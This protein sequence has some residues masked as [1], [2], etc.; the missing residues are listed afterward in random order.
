MTN[1]VKLIT[2][3][4]Y[5]RLPPAPHVLIKLID[6]CH[7][8]DVSF[9]ELEAII[10]KDTALCAKVITISN[11]AAYSQWNETRELKRILVVLGTKTIKSIAITSAVHQFFSQF[12]KEMGETLGSAWLD[13]LICAH[14]ARKLANLT[15]YPF[16]DEAHLAGLIHQ[17]GQLILYTNDPA[18]YQQMMA[19]VSDQNALMFK[20]QER[21]G[22]NSADLA[23]D[24]VAQWG[25]DS[26]LSDAIRY[27]HKPAEL[28]L[29]THP[30][31]RLTS[32]SSQLCNRLNHNN[33]KFMAE[34]Q[35]FGLNQS[36]IENLVLEATQLAVSD[37]RGFG[38][39]VDEDHTIPRANVDQESIRI[40]LAKKMRQIALLEGVQKNFDDVDD[41][42]EMIQLISDQLLLL[43]G[44]SSTMFFFPDK[45][46]TVL[47]GFA[48]HSKNIPAS[49]S[50]S[51]KLK[52]NRSLVSEAALQ[53]QLKITG[54]QT[55]FDDLP[56]IDVQILSSL[57]C[58]EMICL[59]LLHN[60]NLIAVIA[61]G[62]NS[63]ITEKFHTDDEL[64]LHFATIV[65]EAFSRQH[66]INNKYQQQLLDQ[67]TEKDIHTRKVIHEI[68]NP[69]SIIN[70]YLELLSMGMDPESDNKQ[71]LET[72]KSEVHRVS[73]IL[74]QL[75]DD[76]TLDDDHA[77]VNINTLINS[78]LDV[79]KPTLYKINR[80]NSELQLDPALP[81]I[82][83]DAN[84]LKQIITN[85]V[86]NSAE[87]LP[88]K[89]TITIKTKSL[90]V[91]NKSQYI[92]IT[93]AD[94]GEGLPSSVIEH[95]FTPVQT[96]KGPDHSGL[97]LTIV[98]K[99]VVDLNGHISYTTSDSG[100]AAFI[101]LLPR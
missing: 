9:E 84:K 45:E 19:S 100:G 6:L 16:P 48:S 29:D 62:C 88:E 89:G 24:I 94:D 65:S 28:L 56:I 60:H 83:T 4:D 79:F 26:I 14:L 70:N 27:Q 3:L 87:A 5:T 68:N 73:K 34:D 43:F 63:E 23:A 69:L 76:H 51:I 75:K 57:V 71:H 80:I 90:V 17:M 39:E 18:R 97:G 44:L 38:I 82:Q 30:L 99:L 25:V 33:R 31:V 95:L 67:Q 1:S 59:P 81:S 98:N 46:Q 41:L 47:N 36:I 8:T 101:I 77:Q 58:N 12:S 35:F 20:E 15:G 92:E 72:I 49:G 53:Q 66:Q 22:K 86:K 7:R 91:V 96:S 32:L 11:S 10:E 78:M 64:L 52:P 61:I 13:A 40:Q 42:T 54:Y 93:I 37:A 55:D 50:Y 85:L 21:Y 2:D 74:M